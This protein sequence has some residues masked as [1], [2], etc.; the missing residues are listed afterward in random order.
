VEQLER[1]D[2]LMRQGETKAGGVVLSETGRDELGWTEAEAFE[3]L[4]GLGFAPANRPG[5]GEPTAW[6]RRTIH[7]APERPAAAQP[8]SPFAALAALQAQPAAPIHRPRKRRRK[9]GQRPA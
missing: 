4:R 5:P 1:L 2:E 6:R 7:A 9:A 8:L 3:V